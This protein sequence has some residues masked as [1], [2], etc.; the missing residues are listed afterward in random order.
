MTK[1][2][3][4]ALLLLFSSACMNIDPPPALKDSRQYLD[5]IV[6]DIE[7]RDRVLI[8]PVRTLYET[9]DFP[10]DKEGASPARP[11][12]PNNEDRILAYYDPPLSSTEKDELNLFIEQTL[13]T[14]FRQK[15]QVKSFQ[16]KTHAGDKVTDEELFQAA[17]SQGA[18]LVMR[19]DLVENR[20]AYV[21][22]EEFDQVWDTTLV[23]LFP[24][25]HAWIADEMFVCTRQLNINFYDVRDPRRP[26]HTMV[27]RGRHR[28]DLNEFQHGYVL[29]N[30]FQGWSESTDRFTGKNW[31]RVYDG[32]LP[33]VQ[34]NLAVEMLKS[35]QSGL[36]TI[37]DSPWIRDQLERGSPER[38]RTVALI[39]GQNHGQAKS[40]KADA[41]AFYDVLTRRFRVQPIHVRKLVGEAVTV[42]QVLQAMNSLKTKAVDQFLFYFSGQGM[43]TRQGENLV[44]SSGKVLPLKKLA[45]AFKTV[46]AENIAT[47]LD[48]SFDD[49]KRGSGRGSRTAKGSVSTKFQSDYLQ[50][51]TREPGR[52]VLAAAGFGAVTGESRGF[53]LMTGLL[54]RQ[55]KEEQSDLDLKSL[56]LLIED[57]FTRSSR[58]RLGRPYTL[59]SR[60]NGGRKSFVLKLRPTE[61]KAKKT[62]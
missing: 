13:K 45:E 43:R 7:F 10:G 48:C 14:N 29:E 1:S 15:D 3:Q 8:A 52:Q 62:K 35:V 36:K 32:F 31:R 17:E 16:S 42:E 26:L 9:R 50:V 55:M 44:L 39:L 6:E 54:V 27:V 59:F 60:P 18:Q 20:I 61:V 53:G 51:L 38:A 28:R 41:E 21:G 40:A 34:Q 22:N 19:V 23:V 4:I 12:I 47:I 25:F 58:A 37:L 33:H 2:L 24:P 49:A 11:E 56:E 57:K 5:N 46:R 30:G